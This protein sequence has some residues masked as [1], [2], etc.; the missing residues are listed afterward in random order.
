MNVSIMQPYLFPYIGYLQLLEAS[1]KFVVFDDVTFINKG[2]INRN[3]ILLN[4][5]ETLFTLPLK[6]ASQNKLINE[7]EIDWN[8]KWADKL[9]K[10]INQNYKKAKEFTAGFE[11]VEGVFSNQSVLL[12]DFILNSL[13]TIKNYLDLKAEIVGST[14]IFLNSQL[15]SQERI[16]D[17][18]KKLSA[19]TYIN[20]IGGQVLYQKEAFIK[21]KIELKFIE[22]Q[23]LPYAQTSKSFVPYLS[24][25]DMIMNLSKEE[26][27][28]HLAA[29]KLID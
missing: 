28:I 7:I 29:Y 27:K 1:D 14:S 24:I 13:V 16:I 15:K 21:E 18:A 3:K 10:S 12:S 25:I 8:A 23:I 22:T 11:L 9:L 4:G 19:T 5:A 2:W 6:N 26:I 20:A 17:I